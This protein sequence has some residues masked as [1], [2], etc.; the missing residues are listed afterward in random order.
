MRLDRNTV[1]NFIG[2]LWQI[3]SEIP[4][5]GLIGKF[6]SHY[7][8]I[9]KINRY[10]IFSRIIGYEVKSVYTFFLLIIFNIE[11]V[12]LLVILKGAVRKY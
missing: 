3:K 10:I 7:S 8:S 2:F 1:R 4:T 5:F 12:T 11:V 9:L 6:W